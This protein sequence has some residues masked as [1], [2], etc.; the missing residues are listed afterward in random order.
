MCLGGSLIPARSTNVARDSRR[1]RSFR[2]RL[3]LRSMLSE[4]LVRGLR[5]LAA[6]L[7]RVD[8]ILGT[9]FLLPDGRLVAHRLPGNVDAATLGGLLVKMVSFSRRAVKAIA[10][11]PGDY[12]MGRVD[13]GTQSWLTYY[14]EPGIVLAVLVRADA[15]MGL[16]LLSCDQAV[17]RTCEL[18]GRTLL[19]PA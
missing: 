2:S 18:L 11:A 7:R 5:D 4:D 17:A 12:R 13:A 16:V 1:E 8:G 6:S 14:V 10:G 9:A 3:E 15:N 19:A